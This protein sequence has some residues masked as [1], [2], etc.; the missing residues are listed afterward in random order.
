MYL[1]SWTQKPANYLQKRKNIFQLVWYSVSGNNCP[2]SWSHNLYKEYHMQE[3]IEVVVEENSLF[4]RVGMAA[5]HIK[6]LVWL[7]FHN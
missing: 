1:C 3:N 5:S 2:S 6:T 4:S 7:D